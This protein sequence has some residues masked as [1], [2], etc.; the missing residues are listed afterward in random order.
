[1]RAP[2][3][4]T[5]LAT[6]IVVTGL[7]AV[8]GC[9]GDTRRGDDLSTTAGVAASAYPQ[10]KL[11]HGP[12]VSAKVTDPARR[13]YI[14]RADRVCGHFDPKRNEARK[15]AGEAA[16]AAEAVTSYD[17]GVKLGGQQLRALEA[18]P[19]P[20]SDRALLR[21]NVFT[22]LKAQLAIRRRIAPALA[23][24]DVAALR[25]LQSKLDALTRSL[26]GFAHGYGYRVC[27][28]G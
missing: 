24:G 2:R 1:M 12:A 21:A 6:A 18:I 4:R 3:T 13:A 22:P 19:P 26:E 11:P 28:G 9:G 7:I 20:P 8:A 17:E 5:A 15:H 27:G 10:I 14:A 23:Q 16:D 25:P